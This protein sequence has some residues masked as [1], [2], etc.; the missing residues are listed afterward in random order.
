MSVI[1]SQFARPH[2][3][4]GKLIGRGMARGNAELSRWVVQQVGEHAAGDTAKI[5]EIGPG[6]GIGLQETLRRFPDARVWGIDLSPE[7]LAQ[8]RKRNLAEVRYGRLVLVQG[9]IA[10]LADLAPLDIVIANHVLYFWHRPADELAAIRACLRDGGLL[11]LGYQ[12]K[13]NMPPLAQKHFPQQGHVLYESDE[14]LERLLRS[15]GF[16]AV[17]NRIKGQPDAPQG[18]LAMACA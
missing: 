13:Q 17:S 5:A 12:L 16:S 7:M 9:D 4:L 3:L 1:A 6:P 18:R 14:D 2:G 11:A 10:R 8:S 15:A